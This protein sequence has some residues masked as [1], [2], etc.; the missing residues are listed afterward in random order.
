[1]AASH[2]P[3]AEE[4]DEKDSPNWLILISC[5]VSGIILNLYSVG[6]GSAGS[7]DSISKASSAGVDVKGV[8]HQ[9]GLPTKKHDVKCCVS[10][11]RNYLQISTRLQHGTDAAGVKRLTLSLKNEQ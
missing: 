6:V 5:R 7:L 1:M 3:A 8:L 2:R 10:S 9:A 11:R 4:K